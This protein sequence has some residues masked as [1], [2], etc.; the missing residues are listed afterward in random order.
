MSRNYD[1]GKVNAPM[2]RGEEAKKEIRRLLSDDDVRFL[3]VQTTG[4]GEDSRVLTL[5]LMNPSGGWVQH[6]VNPGVAITDEI[7]GFT[8]ITEEDLEDCDT[9]EKSLAPHLQMLFPGYV[10]AGWNIS[11]DIA[12][13]RREQKLIGAP[14]PFQGTKGIWDVM[15]LYSGAIGKD[16]RFSR[17]AA[18]LGKKAPVDP[19]DY[20]DEMIELLKRVSA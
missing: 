9:W 14:D 15:E 6:Y 19:R 1:F 4:L 7:T 12:A 11:F 16:T 2:L 8:G 18:A 17:F 13:I 3:K 20:L 5:T 10:I